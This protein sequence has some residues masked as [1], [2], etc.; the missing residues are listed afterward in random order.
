MSEEHKRKISE[1]MKGKTSRLGY[2]H[3]KESKKKM[4]EAQK[5]KKHTKETKKKMSETRKGTNNGMW[6]GGRYKSAKGYIYTLMPEH[7][8]ANNGGNRYVKRSHL[9]M[10]KTLRRYLRPGEIVHHVNGI[11][12]DDRPENL[13]LFP[14]TG[15]HSKFHR[16]K[17]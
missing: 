2:K 8:H 15:T 7:P 5:G 17:R 12:D 9:I 14:N 1:A 11:K 4:S 16:A 10:E 3:S 6:K 13:Q